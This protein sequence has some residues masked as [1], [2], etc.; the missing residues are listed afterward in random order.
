VAVGL[1]VVEAA[2]WQSVVI[3]A[4][5]TFGGCLTVNVL[6][7]DWEGVHELVAVSLML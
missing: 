2:V 5:V 7:T 6:I 3:G 4:I 1:T